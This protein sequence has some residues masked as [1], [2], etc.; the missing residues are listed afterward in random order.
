MKRFEAVGGLLSRRRRIERG[1]LLSDYR[2]QRRQ[3]DLHRVP[4]MLRGHV[5]IVVAIDVACAGHVPPRD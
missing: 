3:V 1:K 5:L 4:H 2:A